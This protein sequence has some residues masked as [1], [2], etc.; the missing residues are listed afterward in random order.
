MKNE[1]YP[2]EN[3]GKTQ[4]CTSIKKSTRLHGGSTCVY[5]PS[6]CAFAE[7]FGLVGQSDLNDPWDVSGRCLHP[8][9]MWRDQLEKEG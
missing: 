3:R 8:D 5:E 6:W 2:L 1:T 7:L 4:Q 9:G